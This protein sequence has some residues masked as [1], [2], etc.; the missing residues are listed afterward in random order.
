MNKK[1]LISSVVEVL[2]E[3]GIRKPIS[4]PRQVFHISDEEGNQKDFIVRKVDKTTAYNSGDVSAIVDAC[5]SVIEDSLIHGEEVSVHGFGSLGVHKRA[6]RRTK[7]PNTGEPIE[8]DAH[9][10]P[11]FSFGN[12]LRMAAKL[13]E[14]SLNDFADISEDSDTIS[15]TDNIRKDG[16]G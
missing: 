5:I 8:I 15:L 10:I 3:K 9:Y 2:R 6:A 7:H 14:L 4:V 12:N 16:D 1:K 13:Y 11:K